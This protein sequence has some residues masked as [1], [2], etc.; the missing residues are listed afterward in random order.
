MVR[1]T[2]LLFNY[3]PAGNLKTLIPAKRQ[4]TPT[5]HP[6]NTTV[7]WTIKQYVPMSLSLENKLS[8]VSSTTVEISAF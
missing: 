2:S 6:W 8:W 5:S 1:S 4:P 7:F 3:H